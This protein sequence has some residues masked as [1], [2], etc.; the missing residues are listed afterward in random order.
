MHVWA[1]TVL[2]MLQNN[3]NAG[4][5]AAGE[6][7]AKVLIAEEVQSSSQELAPLTI[8]P[9]LPLPEDSYQLIITQLKQKVIYQKK[10]T[11]LLMH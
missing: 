8:R 2:H 6:V 1:D 7:G 4:H 10:K 3:H 5:W 9:P 11:I